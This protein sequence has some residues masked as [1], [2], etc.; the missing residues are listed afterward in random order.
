MN[1]AADISVGEKIYDVVMAGFNVHFHLGETG[2]VGMRDSIAREVIARG[3]YE[4]LS[5]ERGDRCFS[6]FVHVRGRFVAVVNSAELD[7]VLS[8][9]RER[10][11]RAA[12]LAINSLAA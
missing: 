10:H 3:H 1:H 12:A 8:S 4:A 6:E 5:R 7:S 9:L 11:S 2:D